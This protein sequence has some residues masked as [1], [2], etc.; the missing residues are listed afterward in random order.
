MGAELVTFETDEEFDLVAGFLKS[1]GIRSEYWT[2]GNDL[3]KT[4]TH[5]WFTNGRRMEINRWAPHQ[6]DNDGGREHCVHLGYIYR[7]SSEIQLNDR[8]C[9]EDGASLF[10]FICE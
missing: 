8:P 5:N 1:R 6:P 3:G 7:S 10:N 9:S 2:S 4:G